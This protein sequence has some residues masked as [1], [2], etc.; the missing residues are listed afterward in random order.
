MIHFMPIYLYTYISVYLYVYIYIPLIP[1]YT[2]IYSLYTKPNLF[3]Y[4]CL[5]NIC[6]LPIDA[7][8]T[9]PPHPLPQHTTAP[10][11]GE[12][13]APDL[14]AHIDVI[15]HHRSNDAGQTSRPIPLHSDQSTGTIRTMAK[16]SHWK[17]PQ[18][19]PTILKKDQTSEINL[20]MAQSCSISSWSSFL[21]SPW[22][23]P[24]QLI[25]VGTWDEI[26]EHSSVPF[27]A[28]LACGVMGFILATRRNRQT[29]DVVEWVD[30]NH[31][32]LYCSN[33]ELWEHEF[34]SRPDQL[35]RG[36]SKW[37]RW[38]FAGWLNRWRGHQ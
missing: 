8:T 17:S 24:H 13:G 25:E 16:A 30:I 34:E 33:V 23:H 14:G 20:P 22:C 10:A 21:M 7:T 37:R 1:V 2:Y 36:K 4:H 9:P 18:T 26:Q 19:L 11:Y 38:H 12:E 31:Q 3:N 27:H 29:T 35:D 28:G 32:T 6:W 5:P 15:G